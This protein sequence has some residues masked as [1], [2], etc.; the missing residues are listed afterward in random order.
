MVYDAATPTA[1]LPAPPRYC[2]PIG[3]SGAPG[4]RLD[5]GFQDGLL[6]NVALK[7]PT[8]F[9]NRWRDLLLLLRR[10][11]VTLV[12]SLVRASEMIARYLGRGAHHNGLQAGWLA[13]VG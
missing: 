11:W 1:S 9:I 5:D 12:L 2:S 8:I 3:A 4:D 7:A 13:S 10:T 6:H